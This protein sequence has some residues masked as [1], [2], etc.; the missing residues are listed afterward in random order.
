MSG[1]GERIKNGWNAF[2]GRDPTKPLYGYGSSFRPDRIRLSRTNARSIVNSIYNRI[3]IDVSAM[4]VEHVRLDENGNY[5]ET[6]NDE[7]NR[8][9][10]R[11]ANNDQTGRALFQDIVMSMF[12]EG[13]VAVIPVDTD[14]DPENTESYKINSLRTGKIVEWYP[15]EVRVEAY[16]ERVGRKKEIIL[17]KSLVAIIENPFYSI[18]NEPNSTLQ[19]LIRV[20]S[21][22][23]RTNEETS[24]GKMDLIVQLPYTVKSKARQI[25]AESRRKDLEAQLTGSQ[26]GIGYIDGT[27]RVIQLNRSIENNLW[28]QAKDLTLDLYNQLGLTQSI[29]DGTAD[30]KTLLN[31]YDRTVTPTITAIV[32]EMERKWLSKTAIAQRQAIRY[33]RDPFKLIP[34]SQLSDISDKL[35]RNEIMTSNEVRAVIG[36]KPS[37]DPKADE[38]RNSNLNHPEDE[39]TQEDLKETIDISKI[40]EKK[41]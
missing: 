40:S 15:Y 39:N 36:L 24:A 34:V 30:E 3:A 19:R 37:N 29:F 13:C 12:D 9:L 4:N 18:M 27:E 41:I 23:D 35:T 21:Q 33:F 10:T 25:Q 22:L 20:L 5:K 28:T 7:L 1:L 14:I 38:L 6:I 2:K 16:D 32:E 31:Y 17:P 8:V 11:S 26:Y